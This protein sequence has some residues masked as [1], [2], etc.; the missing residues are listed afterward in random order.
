MLQ[1]GGGARKGLRAL[2]DVFLRAKLVEPLVPNQGTSYALAAPFWVARPESSTG[3][4]HDARPSKTPGVP[5]SDEPRLNRTSFALALGTPEPSHLRT[6][7][8]L[9]TLP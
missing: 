6:I 1:P 7:A 8:P 2:G 5:P 9:L 3:A 4:G